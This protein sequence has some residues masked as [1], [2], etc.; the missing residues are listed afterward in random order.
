MLGW[1]VVRG[2]CVAIE[3]VCKV[4]FGFSVAFVCICLSRSQAIFRP[5]TNVFVISFDCM[6]QSNHEFRIILCLAVRLN[7]HWYL[8]ARKWFALNWHI[9]QQQI[10]EESQFATGKTFNT[11]FHLVLFH[12]VVDYRDIY[13]RSQQIDENDDADYAFVSVCRWLCVCVQPEQQVVE[14]NLLM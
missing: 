10:R 2:A 12:F 3:I 8:C 5:F 6:R 14:F 11:W 9:I 7:R 4:F 13:R 1:N